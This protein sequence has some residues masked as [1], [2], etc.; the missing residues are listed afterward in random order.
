MIS[1]L[2]YYLIPQI[3]SSRGITWWDEMDI[4]PILNDFT[5]WLESH[6]D[7]D[8]D[9]GDSLDINGHD[10]QEDEGLIDLSLYLPNSFRESFGSIYIT[11]K[12]EQGWACTEIWYNGR[13]ENDG[14]V[15]DFWRNE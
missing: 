10:F 9:I 13:D 15:T 2:P 1:P 4:N 5:D 12:A 8:N 6:P 11:W 7:V 3:F 14:E